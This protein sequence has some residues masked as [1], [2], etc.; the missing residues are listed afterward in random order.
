ML[1]GGPACRRASPQLYVVSSWW[2]LAE[3]S[4]P[5]VLLALKAAV[6]LACLSSLQGSFPALL[7][8]PP[9]AALP[10][11]QLFQL[12]MCRVEWWW[13]VGVEWGKKA[14]YLR[15]DNFDVFARGKNTP[16]PHN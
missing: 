5:Q 16:A 6:W 12:C 14:V 7:G 10:P 4:S 8:P 11:F 13:V 3:E 9:L 15:C 1:L 2:R